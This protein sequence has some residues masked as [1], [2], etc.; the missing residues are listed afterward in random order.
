MEK[1]IWRPIKGYENRYF[2]SNF[3]RVKGPLKILKPSISNWGYERV[4]IVDNNGKRTSPRV[5]R[6]VAQAFIPNPKNKPQ[7]NHIDGNKLNNNVKNL[8]WATASENKLHDVGQLG[9]KPWKMKSKKCRCIET[10][11]EY[12]SIHFASVSTG[13]SKTQLQ[14]H[15][16][17][18]RSHAGNLHWKYIK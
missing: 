14:E 10:G 16:K 8:E 13:I 2:V 15:L 17:G 18:H 12:H 3:G 1:E 4:R 5:H 7:V 11:K 6:L 9:A